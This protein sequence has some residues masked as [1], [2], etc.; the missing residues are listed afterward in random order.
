M[1]MNTVCMRQHLGGGGRHRSQKWL[2]DPLE[3]KLQTLVSYHMDTKEPRSL[4]K[5]AS[6][7]NH[8]AI[9]AALMQACGLV[10][11]MRPQFRARRGY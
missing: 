6:A 8:V 11:Q 2:L 1:Y 9:S 4:E 3:L 5:A 7:L 10:A